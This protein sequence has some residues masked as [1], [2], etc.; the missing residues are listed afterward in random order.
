MLCPMM[1]YRREHCTIVDCKKE[2]CAWYNKNK[3]ECCIKVLSEN[4]EDVTEG[5]RTIFI[6][7]C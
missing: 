4:I 5:Q 6:R 7:E 3:E 1:S 2:E